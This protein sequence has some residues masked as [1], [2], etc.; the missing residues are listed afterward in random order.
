MFPEFDSLSREYDFPDQITGFL[1]VIEKT[2]D[3]SV[4]KANIFIK[5]VVIIYKNKKFIARVLVFF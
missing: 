2:P 1:E 3:N 5:I 4:A